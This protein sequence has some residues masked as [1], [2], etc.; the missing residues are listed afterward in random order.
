VAKQENVDLSFISDG[1]K[2]WQIIIIFIKQGTFKHSLSK[3][4]FTDRRISTWS[5]QF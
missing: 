4:N 1:R 5:A 3:I 2:L